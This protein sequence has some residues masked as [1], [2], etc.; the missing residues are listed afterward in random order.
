MIEKIKIKVKQ[1][2]IYLYNLINNSLKKWYM[3]I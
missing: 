2:I 3:H 1:T